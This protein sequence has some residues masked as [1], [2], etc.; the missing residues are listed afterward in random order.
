MKAFA[1]A[2]DAVLILGTALVAFAGASFV[3][4]SLAGAELSAMVGC[5]L[6]MVM[7]ARR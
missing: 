5:C 1:I 3:G 6:G 7:A 2:F 4:A